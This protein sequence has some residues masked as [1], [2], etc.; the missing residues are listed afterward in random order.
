M[1]ILEKEIEDVIYDAITS[2][3]NALTEHG[4]ELVCDMYFRQ[5]DLGEFGIADIIG[6][7]ANENKEYA[8]VE[9]IELKKDMVNAGAFFQALRYARALQIIFNDFKEVDIRII[10]IG[11]TIDLKS[12]ACF[13][14]D[15][16]PNVDLFTWNIDL[17]LGIS[18]EQHH[19]YSPSNRTRFDVI[20]EGIR[21][22]ETL[23]TE[24][25]AEQNPT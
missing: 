13:L 11:K 9:I 7:S 2:D 6:V 5:F 20:K 23:I 8:K 14:S 17:K 18:F 1:N 21:I 24:K 19:G 25:N 16:F 15:I 4:L 10:L 3:F 22:N 12:D